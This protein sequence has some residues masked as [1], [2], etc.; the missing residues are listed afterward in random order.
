MSAFNHL[1][2][3]N[4]LKNNLPLKLFDTDDNINESSFDKLNSITRS[5]NNISY[6]NLKK[7]AHS[8]TFEHIIPKETDWKKDI[9]DYVREKKSL[10]WGSNPPV[11]YF[12]KLYINSEDR[13]F[14]PITQKYL[15]KSR[16]EKMNNQQKEDLINS[17]SKGLDNELRISQTFDI[18]NL[19]DK[20]KGFEKDKNYPQSPRVRRKKYYNLTPKINYN[21]LSN[22]NYKIHH[23]DKP[24][25][26]PNIIFDKNNLNG[27]F[28]YKGNHRNKLIVTKGL[29]DF[30]ILSNE[31][32]ENSDKKHKI[33]NEVYHLNA[34]KK[35]YKY[36]ELN[37]LTGIYYDEEK[38]KS[39]QDKKELIIKKL[40]NKKE[41]GLYNPFNFKVYD[42]EKL[43]Q[44]DQ[45]N[46]NRIARY[47]VNHQLDDYYKL[48]NKSIDEKRKNAL[49]H[50]ISYNRYKQIDDR[51]Y[52]FLNHQEFLSL[53]KDEKN[54]NDKT[55]WKLIKEGCNEN[56]T[57]SKSQHLLLRDKDDLL[58]KYADVKIKREEKIKNLPRL[59]SDPLF[60]LKK[61]SSKINIEFNKPVIIPKNKS[62]I[63]NKKEWFSS[64]ETK[65]ENSYY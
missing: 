58:R 24:E 20:L 41:K 22:L 51:G 50:R 9:N 17:I 42:E 19:Q 2:S 34:S 38:E 37:P 54:S 4:K 40:L 63:F 39:F 59:D 47:K 32:Y 25:K 21:I 27:L 56:E 7:L 30:N 49:N 15:D 33:D 3:R 60:Q 13:L 46:L 64:G 26:R 48:W 61:S 55:P 57:I 43:K 11:R 29:K 53:K 10:K 23:Y 12:T 52:D 18:I 6:Q 31:Y 65:D 35:F 36:R 16:E 45:I 8:Q 44:K 14:N 5:N 28:H 62:F 1:N